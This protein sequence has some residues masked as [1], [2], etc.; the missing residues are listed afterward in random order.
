MTKNTLFAKIFSSGLQAISVQV[1]GG[2][3]FYFISI[4]LT[5][6][7]F[8]IIGWANAVSMFLTT[9]LGFG[10]EQVVVR[11]IAASKR[12]DWA[13]AAFF[14]HSVTGFIAVFLLLLVLN[15]IIKTDSGIN[16]MLP[17]FFLAQ[18]LIYIAV[19]LKQFLN[20]KEQF[21][22]Y[23]ILA[24][25]SNLAKTFIAWA[26]V[27]KSLLSV[28]TVLVILIITAGFELCCLLVY[29]LVKTGFS[30]SF[31]FGAYIKLLKESS[32]QYLSVIFDSSLSRMDWILLGVMTSGP[33]LADYSFAYRAYELAR[34]PLLIIAPVIL[35]RFARLFSGNN[36]IGNEHQNNI[37]SFYRV[38]MFLAAGIPLL[39]NI[40]WTPL[41][42][43]IT[44][45]K[46]GQSNAMEFLILS[47]CIPLQFFIN[48]LWSLCFGAKLYKQV[49][50]IT[51]ICAVTNVVLNV[52]LIHWFNGEGA[53]IAFLA[54]T[55]LQAVLYYRLAGKMII[56]INIWPIILFTA[57][58]LAIYFAVTQFQLHFVFQLAMAAT[59]YVILI[60]A[61]KQIKKEHLTNFKRLLT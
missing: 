52:V 13:A 11:R 38:E 39:L 43:I 28:N 25:I 51:V 19:P 32:A 37:N 2:L 6:N 21:T 31:R 35:P 17:W 45:G 3:F 26:L 49:S 22:P 10:L 8:G 1:L 7:D 9:L 18:G 4:Y 54:T 55:L 40:L 16:K 60:I 14:L 57:E 53:A 44:H 41:L 33:V 42:S 48:L 5:K 24:V 23:G 58:A 12:S 36:P 29:L 34:L 20:A 15:N 30:F 56:T 47:L 27:E 59:G 46:Y 61:S 50:Y